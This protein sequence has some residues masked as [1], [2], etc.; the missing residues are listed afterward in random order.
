MEVEATI[1][2]MPLPGPTG[3]HLVESARRGDTEAREELARRFRLPAYRLALQLLGD[4]DDAMDVAQDAMVRFFTNLDRFDTGRPVLP[5][6]FSIVHNRARDLQRRRRRRPGDFGDSLVDVDKLE[7]ADRAADPERRVRRR[8]L[9]Q[10]IWKALAELS[11]E[12]RQVLVLRDYQDLTYDEIARVLGI[13]RGTVMSRLHRARRRLRESY[14]ATME[15]TG[16]GLSSGGE[17]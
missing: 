11:A 8:E 4:K 16:D 6:L 7:M 17:A 15:Q 3:R 13:P 1:P 2:L 14:G 5:W 10:R 9:R 12:H